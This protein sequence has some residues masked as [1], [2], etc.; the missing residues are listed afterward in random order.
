MKDNYFF[1]TFIILVTIFIYEWP[2]IKKYP[3][4]DKI[5]FISLII[6]CLGLSTFNLPLTKG[7]ISFFEKVYGPMG[8]LLEN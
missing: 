6:I 4:I 8:K 7:P 1:I 5:V 3:I 2:K